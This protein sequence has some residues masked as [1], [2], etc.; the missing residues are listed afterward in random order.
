MSHTAP[1]SSH[2]RL[3][4]KRQRPPVHVTKRRQEQQRPKYSPDHFVGEAH[5]ENTDNREGVLSLG[6]DT[7]SLEQ[8]K[9][10]VYASLARRLAR[11]GRCITHN[12][13]QVTRGAIVNRTKC[14]S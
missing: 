3:W 7:G 6:R 12:E 9:D 14:C 2:R 13:G 5:E 8:K 4:F 11:V 1:D 10:T